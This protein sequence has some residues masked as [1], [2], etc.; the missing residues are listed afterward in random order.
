[1]L[2]RAVFAAVRP[3]SPLVAVESGGVRYLLSTADRV[4]GASTFSWGPPEAATLD[5]AVEILETLRGRALRGRAF[6]DVGANLGTATITALTRFGA[7][8]AVAFEPSPRTF[9][10]LRCNVMIN[11]L[12]ERVRLFDVAL[13]GT[14]GSATLEL[15][16]S[17]WGDSRI[18][19]PTGPANGR[20]GESTWET[21]SVRIE[22]LDDMLVHAGLDIADIG[23]VWIDSQ[24]HEGHV[25]DGALSVVQGGVPVV[26]EYWPYGLRRAGGL[27]SLHE[28]IATNYETVIDLRASMESSRIVSTPAGHVTELEAIYRGTSFTDLLLLA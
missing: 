24:G 16:P 8:F 28:R 22:R 13:S 7:S 20:Y 17:N 3:F 4:V 19:P 6:V 21:A 23:L 10:L 27:A 11:G 25:L 15:S 18:R 9:I 2:R 5:C 1:M 14:S 26:L 12:A